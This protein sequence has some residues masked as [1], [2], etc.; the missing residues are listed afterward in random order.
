MTG[1]R[2]CILSCS[3]RPANGLNYG[4]VHFPQLPREAST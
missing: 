1:G 3:R 2:R 4:A